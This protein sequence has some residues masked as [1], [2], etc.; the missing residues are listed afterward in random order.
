MSIWVLGA[1]GWC[2][3]NFAFVVAVGRRARAGRLDDEAADAPSVPLLSVVPTH[4]SKP[5][6]RVA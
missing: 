2:V 4:D 6:K 1:L 5:R 3:I